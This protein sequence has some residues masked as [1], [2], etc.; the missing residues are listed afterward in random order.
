M[1][2]EEFKKRW[3]APNCDITFDDIADCAKEWGL[4]SKPKCFPVDAV[5][6]GVLVAAGC[7]DAEDY[8]PEED[9]QDIY[10]SNSYFKAHKTEIGSQRRK[11]R[12]G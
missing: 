12:I 6:Y 10:K 7:E 3:N 9:E 4:H 5:R 8:R 2:K 11:N 1:T